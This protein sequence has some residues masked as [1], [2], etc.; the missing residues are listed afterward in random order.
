MRILIVDDAEDLLMVISA[1]LES[2]G[3]EAITCSDGQEAW[4]LI[5]REEISFIISDW[6]MPGLNGLELCRRIRVTDFGRYIY[7]ILLTGREGKSSLIEGMDAGADEFLVK[8]VD[9]D[10]LRVR[11]RAG[12]RVLQLE[13][14]LEERNRTLTDAYATIRKDLEAAAKVQTGW[15]PKSAT[16][17]GVRFDRLFRPCSFVAGD[18][19]D[20]FA[21]DHH[22]LGFYQLDV[23]GHGV[24]SALMSFS[25]NRMLSQGMEGRGFLKRAQGLLPTYDINPPEQVMAELNR[26]F[27]TAEDSMLYF[28]MVYGVIDTQTRVLTFTQ[29]GHPP[30]IWV[31]KAQQE[32]VTVGHGGFPVGLLPDLDYES[33]TL[34]LQEGDRLFLY[35]D[36]ITECA[37]RAN[38]QFSEKRLLQ[39]LDQH[40]DQPLGPVM[41]ILGDA[42][43]DWKGSEQYEDDVSLLALEILPS[44]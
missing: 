27:E 29:A 12:E 39:I 11:L 17:Q 8:P 37:N 21:L 23:A 25:L 34:E 28:T 35:S 43:R 42:L 14:Q 26:R 9:K 33:I 6:M 7:F 5:R 32:A 18:A 19:F 10:E 24:P 36:G 30:P 20:Y 15:L 2:W 16:L 40:R 31:R 3:Y 13:R 41:S 1:M 22:H 38:E 4:D 44:N